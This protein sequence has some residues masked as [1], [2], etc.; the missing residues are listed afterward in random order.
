MEAMEKLGPGGR[1]LKAVNALN[2]NWKSPFYAEPRH[3]ISGFYL[4]NENDA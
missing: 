2:V 3:A 4:L 1:N